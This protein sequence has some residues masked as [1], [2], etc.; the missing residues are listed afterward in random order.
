MTPSSRRVMFA[1]ITGRLSRDV[2]CAL[3]QTRPVYQLLDGVLRQKMVALTRE[4]HASTHCA[5]ALF[6]WGQK[7]GWNLLSNSFAFSVDEWNV[8]VPEFSAYEPNLWPVS[9]EFFATRASIIGEVTTRIED[10]WE[11]QVKF[12]GYQ[13]AGVP[14]YL[15]LDSENR[16]FKAYRLENGKYGPPEILQGSAIWQPTEFLGLRLEL[17]QLWMS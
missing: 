9:D 17:S 14:L 8:F 13:K 12:E 2:W 16:E 4:S 11:R 5:F 1:P 15:L 6:H 3:P 10:D 7:Y